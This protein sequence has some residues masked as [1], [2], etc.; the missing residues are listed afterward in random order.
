MRAECALLKAVTARWVMARSGVEAAQARER[1]LL[2]ELIE[3]V[4]ARAPRDFEA[5]LLPEWEA[6][7]DDGARRA[8]QSSTRWRG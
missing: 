6:A 1:E 8:R 5:V 4:A 7:A 3:A 2:A